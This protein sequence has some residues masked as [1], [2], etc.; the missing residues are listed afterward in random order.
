MLGL[1]YRKPAGGWNR[2]GPPDPGGCRRVRRRSRGHR[3]RM[4]KHVRAG[5][6]RRGRSLLGIERRR[7]VG[8]RYLRRQPVSGGSERPR[9]RKDRGCGRRRARL[10]ALNHR[11]CEVLGPERSRPAWQRDGR[12][13]QHAD[14]RRRIAGG[15]H[16]DRRREGTHLRAY[17]PGRG[18]VLGRER[19]RPA[20]RRHHKRFRQTGGCP[21]ACRKRKRDRR[22]ERAYLRALPRRLDEV[23][24]IEYVRSA[25]R[26]DARGSPCAGG[27]ERTRRR[28]RFDCGGRIPHLRD[29]LRRPAEVLGMERVRPAW[30]QHADR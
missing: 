24:G 26:W 17:G 12:R 10:R 28:S 13:P 11:R 20:G 25:G 4:G 1:E 19:V 30:R 6:D 7:P 5:I 21:R 9:L 18:E 23:L 3:G 15:D 8:R 29:R 16:R 14:R 22:R 27:C 2:Q